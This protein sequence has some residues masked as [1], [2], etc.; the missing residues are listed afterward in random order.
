MSRRCSSSFRHPYG[1]R[2][3]GLYTLRTRT[4]G[5]T[6]SP[7][8]E[9]PEAGSDYGVPLATVKELA[10]RWRTGFDWRATEARLNAFPQF[11]TEIDGEMILPAVVH[12]VG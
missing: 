12:R 7:P 5:S 6:N 11:T 9:L 4:T 1:V 3:C 8:T 10:E 2:P